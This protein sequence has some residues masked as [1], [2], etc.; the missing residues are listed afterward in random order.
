VVLFLGIPR[1]VHLRGLLHGIIRPQGLLGLK[2]GHLPLLSGAFVSFPTRSLSWIAGCLWNIGVCCGLSQDTTF[3]P[4]QELSTSEPGPAGVTQ[5]VT[6]NQ[7]GWQATAAGAVQLTM[8]SHPPVLGDSSPSTQSDPGVLSQGRR[9]AA[10]GA[11]GGSTA[12]LGAS[13]SAASHTGAGAAG[14]GEAV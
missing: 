4:Y 14:G 10:L 8:T 6:T 2:W 9:T 1:L 7:S 11:R 5:P 3:Q 13:S 12:A